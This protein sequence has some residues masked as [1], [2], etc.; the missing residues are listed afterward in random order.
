VADCRLLDEPLPDEAAVDV[1]LREATLLTEGV[2]RD[3]IRAVEKTRKRMKKTRPTAEIGIVSMARL[4]SGLHAG[5]KSDPQLP[6]E[7][8]VMINLTN[9][10]AHAEMP[11]T[12]M[13]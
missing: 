3:R 8:A 9:I 11:A 1:P 13:S 10:T 5:W 2:D 7:M 4:T 12:A 6:L